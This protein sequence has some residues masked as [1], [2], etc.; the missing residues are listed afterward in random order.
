[1]SPWGEPDRSL[2]IMSYSRS[3]LGAEDALEDTIWGLLVYDL[4]GIGNALPQKSHIVTHDTFTTCRI[5]LSRIL[6]RD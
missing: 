5:A 2:F 1:M 3:F 4:R 6:A